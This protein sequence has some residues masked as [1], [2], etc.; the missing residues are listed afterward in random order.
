MSFLDVT[1]A[2][3]KAA[4]AAY[5]HVA[6][7]FFRNVH[8]IDRDPD[9]VFAEV[10]KAMDAGRTPK[11]TLGLTSEH[12]EALLA[13]AHNLIQAGALPEAQEKLL[14]AMMLDPHEARAIYAAAVTLQIQRR[15]ADAGRIYACYVYAKP[16]DPAGYLRIGECLLGEGVLDEAREFVAGALSTAEEAKDALT[17]EQARKV[18]A[19]IDARRSIISKE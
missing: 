3:A 8:G 4:S 15:Y 9:E 19:V 7:K 17:A 11:N 1:P 12:I 18:L 6:G 13:T 14:L 5:K 2:E 16:D 10:F